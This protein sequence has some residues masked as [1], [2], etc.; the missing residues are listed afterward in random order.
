[1]I[2]PPGVPLAAPAFLDEELPVEQPLFVAREQEL[3]QL[4]LHLSGA[5]TGQGRVVFVTGD[6][7]SGKTALA[8]EF[9]RRAQEKHADLVSAAGHGNAQTGVGDPYL[10]F[11]EILGLLTGD[12]QAQWAAGAM[13]REQ[14]RRLW[15]T[16]PTTAQALVE[17]GPDLIDTFVPRRRLL[18]RATTRASGKPAWLAR[19]EPRRGSRP[20]AEPGVAGTPQRDLFEQYT[21]VLQVVA[22]R[23]PLLLVVDDLQWADLGSISLLFHLGRQL[24]GCRILI[25]G[26]FRPEEVALGRPDLTMGHEQ[27]GRHPLE[28]V[29]HEFQRDFGE[30]TVHLGQAGSRKFV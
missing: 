9:A 25:V 12:V 5:L 19:L 4:D 16:L 24:T 7:G 10:P 21:R 29:V 28:P 13:T 15:Q 1:L 17:D 23:G 2:E 18:K 22:Q 20:D 30:I 6:A 11:R 3:A 26:A 27:R 14:A 8:Q